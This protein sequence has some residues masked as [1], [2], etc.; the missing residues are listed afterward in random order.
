VDGSVLR[1]LYFSR[2]YTTHDRRF[3]T[4]F[5]EAGL[6]TA[7]LRLLDERI[8]RRSIPDGVEILGWA[9]GTRPPRDSLDLLHR[10][11]ALREVLARWRPD[12][13]LA[14][15][16]PECA[17]LVAAVGYHPLVAMSWGSDVLADT[18]LQGW[19]G[20]FTR[21]ALR[22]SSAVFGDCE[23]VRRR[24]LALGFPQGGRILTF[25]WGVNL[26]TFSPAPSSLSVRRDLGWDDA[27]VIIS[28]RT[29]EPVYAIDVLVRA[30]VEVHQAHP[31]T[32]LLLLGDGS[33][34]AEII[35]LISALGLD[36]SIHVP[37]R[38]DHEL[39]PDY[40]RAA[41]LYVSSALS[42]GTSVSML[43]AMACG[44]PVVVSSACGNLEWV[45]PGRNGWLAAPGD[46]ESLATAMRTALDARW[47]FGE[48]GSTNLAMVRARADWKANSSTLP[49]LLK[50]VSEEASMSSRG[51]PGP[52]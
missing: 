49:A 23:A 31:E 22:H 52:L 10:R 34:H 8:D 38:V 24:V 7:H 35:E 25:P 21:Y 42:D 9:A 19:N 47:Q 3:L 50:L 5:V 16:I 43:E 1:L 28:T 18:A 45:E 27:T 15:P 29:W 33:Q 51:G 6:E 26:E 36:G 39:L 37:G 44:L 40:F 13:V 12:V 2:A 32:K 46:D 48:I 14:G 30:F 41:D 17:F 11:A 20:R 4:S